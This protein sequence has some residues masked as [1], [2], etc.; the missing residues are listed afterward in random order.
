MS[1]HT[2]HYGTGRFY[3]PPLIPAR[4]PR[5]TTDR[6]LDG[7]TG[8]EPL[9]QLLAAAAGPAQADELGGEQAAHTTFTTAAQFRLPPGVAT[10]H[11]PRRT[12]AQSWIVAAK[13][14]FAIALTAG[15]GGVAVAATSSPF[16]AGPPEVS[17]HQEA[18][19]NLSTARPTVVVDRARGMAPHRATFRCP[20]TVRSY[21]A[22]FDS[23]Q[24][25]ASWTNHRGDRRGR[26][27]H[28]TPRSRAVPPSPRPDLSRRS[29]STA[30][31]QSNPRP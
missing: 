8:P 7:G 13:T 31:F 14:I 19:P 28:H 6:L 12:Q 18:G 15:A 11:S 1:E 21:A 9:R 27:P 30:L 4:L 5:S 29:H 20:G 26:V 10:H 3:M 16:P 24:S 2:R 22:A 23:S 25:Q 17:N